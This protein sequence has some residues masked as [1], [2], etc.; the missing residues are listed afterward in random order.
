MHLLRAIETYLRVTAT[1][2]TRFGREV[3]NDPRFVLD[4]RNGR[5]PRNATCARVFAWLADRETRTR[6][7]AGRR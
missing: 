3:V 7:V 4:L 2:P 1:P 6:P 5:E